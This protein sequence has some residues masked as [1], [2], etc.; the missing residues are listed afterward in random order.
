MS[1]YRP[2]TSCTLMN[3][4]IHGEHVTQVP[5]PWSEALVTVIYFLYRHCTNQLLLSIAV[6]QKYVT[7]TS[8]AHWVFFLENKEVI[9]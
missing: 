1:G 8:T 3:A 2:T 9:K 4:P 7:G 5:T 6:T